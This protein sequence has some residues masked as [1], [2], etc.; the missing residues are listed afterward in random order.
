MAAAMNNDLQT[1]RTSGELSD[2]DLEND[3]AARSWAERQPDAAGRE[4]GRHDDRRAPLPR[5][6]DRPGLGGDGGS[7]GGTPANPLCPVKRRRRGQG[8]GAPPR[9]QAATAIEAHPTRNA[10]PPS[11]VIAPSQRIPV[12]VIT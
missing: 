9:L 6:G 4:A 5:A 1:G 10:T 2:D 3:P 8:F 11:G 7:T 12:S